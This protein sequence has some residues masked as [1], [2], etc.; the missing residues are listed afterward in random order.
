ML[1]PDQRIDRKKNG[2]DIQKEAE[3]RCGRAD[4]GNGREQGKKSG[5]ASVSGS[6]LSLPGSVWFFLSVLFLKE[7]VASS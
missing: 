4:A 3:R 1:A 5:T 6:V 2:T 7:P